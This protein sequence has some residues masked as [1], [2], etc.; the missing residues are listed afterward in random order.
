MK[1]QGWIKLHREMVNWRWYKNRNVKI[2]FIHLILRSNHEDGSY[3]NVTISKGQL[4]T[5]RK[6]L[7]EETGLSDREVRT[8]LRKLEDTQEII[9]KTTSKFSIIT[10]CKWDDYQ[11]KDFI[12]DQPSTN[13]RPTSDQHSTT[14][15]NKKNEKNDEN[16][17]PPPFELVKKYCNERNKGIDPIAFMNHYETNGWRYGKG[18][19]KP[20]KDWKAAVRTWEDHRKKEIQEKGIDSGQHPGQIIVDGTIDA[21]FKTD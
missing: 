2:L 1:N 14:N 20:I 8:A 5:G 9:I 16:T 15:K 21:K 3:E 19:G 13:E 11:G 17:I 10:I 7:S 4:I 12:K 6:R 18:A